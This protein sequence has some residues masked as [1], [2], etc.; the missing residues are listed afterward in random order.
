MFLLCK[1]NRV[2]IVSARKALGE[3]EW[4]ADSDYTVGVRGDTAQPRA[5]V[6]ERDT[7]RCVRGVSQ[8]CSHLPAEGW[9]TYLEA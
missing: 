4:N 3:N 1:R 6:D 5:P 2:S 7:H 9:G 8:E